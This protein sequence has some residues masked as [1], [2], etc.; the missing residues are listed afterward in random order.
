[1]DM[2]DKPDVPFVA[3]MELWDLEDEASP[4]EPRGDNTDAPTAPDRLVRCVP[5][6]P[7]AEETANVFTEG[8]VL[9][10]DVRPEVEAGLELAP[11]GDEELWR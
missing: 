5:E 4:P 10:A 7:L 1:L 11:V 3:R 8:V 6:I 9:L 2:A